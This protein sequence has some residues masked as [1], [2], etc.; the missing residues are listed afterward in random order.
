MWL[1]EVKKIWKSGPKAHK[2]TEGTWGGDMRGGAEYM[3]IG[4]VLYKK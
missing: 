2:R 4:I 1:E 3:A